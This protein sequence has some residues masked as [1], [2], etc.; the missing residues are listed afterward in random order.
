MS[1]LVVTN[2]YLLYN[3]VDLMDHID[4]VSLSMESAA[5][6][7]TNMS[8]AG[9]EEFL[10]GLRSW[11]LDVNFH[12]DFAASKVDAT[13]WAAWLAGAAVAIETRSTQSA[14]S[15]TN[16]KFTG[17]VLPTQYQ[18]VQGKVGDLAVVSISYPG[19]GALA[20]ATS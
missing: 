7:H 3:T 15:A 12:Q 9:W 14:V 5:V 13:L 17:N 20:R 1:T 11:K 6:G 4:S 19:T 10:A 8:S 18:P 2:T 16:P